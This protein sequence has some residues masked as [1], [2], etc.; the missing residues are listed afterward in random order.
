[1]PPGDKK[2]KPRMKPNC[3]QNPGPVFFVIPG[4]IPADYS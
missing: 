4:G 1:M 3:V 2:E